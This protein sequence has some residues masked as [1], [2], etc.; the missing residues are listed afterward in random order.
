MNNPSYCPTP[1]PTQTPTPAPSPTPCPRYTPSSHIP[2]GF[3]V[4]WDTSS[5]STLL[6]KATCT[7]GSVLLDV[8][9]N[10]PL[11]YIY[12]D[13]Y[14]SRGGSAWGKVSLLGSGL[15]AGSW[16]PKYATATIPMT[17]SE[18]AQTN[19]YVAYT[20][21]YTGTQWKCGCRDSACMQ[22]YWQVQQI[23]R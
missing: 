4:P 9:D 13:A 15:I 14:L 18:Q 6:L 19:H 11:R 3:G 21:K 1:T 23:K 5:P 12:K 10:E 22:S 20:C 2:P 7:T 8:G 17:D 16:Y